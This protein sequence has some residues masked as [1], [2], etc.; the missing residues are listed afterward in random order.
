MRIL[1]AGLLGG[2]AIFFWGFLAHTVLPIGEMGMKAPANEDAVLA[3]LRDGLPAKGIYFLP[4][5]DQREMG[6]EAK[7]DAWA[8]KSLASPYAYIVYDPQGRDGR[9][10]GANLG[11]Q[12]ATD[13]SLGLLIAW[14]LSLSSGG[15]GRRLGIG[16]ALGAICWLASPV[17]SWNWYRFPAEYVLAGAIEAIAATVLAALVGGWWLGRKA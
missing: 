3:A 15:I 12:F 7:M 16:A 6:D 4:Y 13:V 2:I 14:I 10:M 5:I 8:Q 1:I 9:E 17:P 11:V